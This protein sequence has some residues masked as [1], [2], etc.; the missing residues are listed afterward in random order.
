MKI[1]IVGGGSGGH[2]T[3]AIAVA[4]EILKQKPRTKIEFWTDRKYFANFKKIITLSGMKADVR[5]MAVVGKFRRYT[6]MKFLDYL[7]PRNF[8]ILWQNVLDF[9]KFIVALVESF[10]KLLFGRPD[11]IFLKGGFVSLPVGLVARLLQISYVIHE[12]DTVPGLTSRLLAPGA[13]KI[14]TGMPISSGELKK[15]G[16]EK[17]EWVGIPV[18]EDFRP[19]SSKEQ[20]ELKEELGFEASRPL[21]LVTGGSQG[22][23]HINETIAKILP[24]VLEISSLILI[25]GRSKYQDMIGLKKHEGWEEGKITSNFRM[26][27]FRTD[28]AKLMGAADLIISRSGATTI[29]EMAAMRKAAILVPYGVLPGKHQTKNAEQMAFD[30]VA[31]VIDDREMVDHPEEMLKL[32]QG[33][34][35]SETEMNELGEKLG[36]IARTDAAE[37]LAEIILKVV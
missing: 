1:V 14:A 35:K 24:E 8:H 23:S 29:A 2:I 27:E 19:V 30:G 3:P 33:L 16:E 18:S 32:I 12:S 21:I 7:H 28:M 11:V 4:E 20:R 22:S 17:L 6:H 10:F 36:K 9:F 15:Y 25:A 37:K 5:Q 31:R 26:F 34:V 13:R